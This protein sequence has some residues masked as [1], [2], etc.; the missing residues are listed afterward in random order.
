MAWGGILW[1]GHGMV[2]VWHGSG[3]VLHGGMA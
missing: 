2:G 3:M 1:H